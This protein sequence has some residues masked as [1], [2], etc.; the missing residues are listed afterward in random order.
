MTYT[1]GASPYSRVLAC[2]P[3]A[4]EI[5]RQKKSL[6]GDD[7]QNFNRILPFGTQPRK[8]SFAGLRRAL[9]AGLNDLFA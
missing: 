8:D 7:E 2:D 3:R 4:A 6:A 1:K 9:A 5:A